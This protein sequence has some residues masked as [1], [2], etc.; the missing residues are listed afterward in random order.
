M[1]ILWLFR[2][3]KL[4]QWSWSAAEFGH[5]H[6]C[7]CA[8][9][10]LVSRTCAHS[11]ARAPMIG[12]HRLSVTRDVRAAATFT[13]PTGAA[14]RVLAGAASSCSLVA[15]RPS[16]CCDVYRFPQRAR[17]VHRPSW[18]VLPVRVRASRWQ[19][20][21][22]SLELTACRVVK[23]GQFSCVSGYY[24]SC[25]PCW[26]Q[27]TSAVVRLG[28]LG[29]VKEPSSAG[30][31]A[32]RVLRARRRVFVPPQA[33]TWWRCAQRSF[34]PHRLGVH[35]PHPVRSAPHN[36]SLEL[37]AFSV[38][39]RRQFSCVSCDDRVCAPRW[40]QLTSAVRRLPAP[41]SRLKGMLH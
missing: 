7:G 22:N 12:A 16:V 32:M 27:R 10:K 41:C 31:R 29:R 15:A 18:G 40:R 33:R 5:W 34:G 17:H 23:R 4:A 26:R 8:L 30:E 39:K 14:G 1:L 2:V 13:S 6:G 21:N 3:G 11:H 19:P 35:P 38:V 9:V 36:T 24:R 25:Y 20:A 37:T 28:L